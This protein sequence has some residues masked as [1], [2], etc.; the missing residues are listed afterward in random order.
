MGGVSSWRRPSADA[1]HP[2]ALVAE[3]CHSIPDNLVALLGR[4]RAWHCS[5]E[6]DDRRR[7]LLWSSGQSTGSNRPVLDPHC[8]SV[9]LLQ[10]TGTPGGTVDRAVSPQED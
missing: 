3:Q 4:I 6:T 1:D 8:R 10:L 2:H 5:T 7:S 9:I